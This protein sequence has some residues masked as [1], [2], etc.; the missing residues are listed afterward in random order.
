MGAMIVFVLVGLWGGREHLRRV[1]R[2]ALGRERDP[3]EA[4]E[5]LSYRGALFGLLGGLAIMA[6][7][8]WRAGV[9]LWITP[10]FFFGAFVIFLALTRAIA[11]AGLPT[12]TPRLIPCDFVISG[13]GVPALGPRGMVAISS[14]SFVWGTDLLIFLMAPV[15]NGLKLSG[16][17]SGSRR[18]LLWPIVTAIAVAFFSA[19]PATLLMAY[20]HGAV[21][22]DT[23][24]FVGFPQH[25]FEYAARKIASPSGPDLLGWVMTIAGGGA[26]GLIMLAQRHFLWWPLHPIGFLVAADWVM[27]NIWFS[28]FL[29]WLVKS[30]V[31]RYGGPRLY[32]TTQ[33]F[34]IG[35]VLGQFTAAGFWL[36]VDEMTGMR[37]S[38][39]HVY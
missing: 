25:P 28:V 16:E 38:M 32:R 26:M 34:F 4:E 8:T 3:G 37:G 12:V 19:V 13:I 23:Q 5:V 22:L 27:N 2:V 36:I 9:P 10:I 14:S 21:N 7:W 15:A 29:A 17:M 1:V 11:E 6:L 20:R 30:L 33:P 18:S 31:L 35:L 24:Y 39:I